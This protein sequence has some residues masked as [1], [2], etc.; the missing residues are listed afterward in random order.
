M[1]LQTSE[2]LSSRSV[3]FV[4]GMNREDGGYEG[5]EKGTHDEGRKDEESGRRTR[6]IYAVGGGVSIKDMGS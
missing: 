2:G 4:V 6:Y 5:E 3:G 1:V